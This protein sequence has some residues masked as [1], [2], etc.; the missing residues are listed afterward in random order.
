MLILTFCLCHGSFNLQLLTKSE[1]AVA[2]NL[3]PKSQQDTSTVVKEVVGL[4]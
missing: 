4:G 2:N 3:N 1:K